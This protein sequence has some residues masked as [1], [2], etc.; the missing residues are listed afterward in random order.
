MAKSTG[1]YARRRNR[2]GLFAA[3]LTA[4]ANRLVLTSALSPRGALLKT[5]L[6]PPLRLLARFFRWWS[7]GWLGQVLGLRWSV[8]TFQRGA[9][10]ELSYAAIGDRWRL[11]RHGNVKVEPP[12]EPD[13]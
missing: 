12:K 8:V 1:S 7:R 9:S 11:Y 6:V 3:T 10:G 13:S 5:L 4:G 2:S